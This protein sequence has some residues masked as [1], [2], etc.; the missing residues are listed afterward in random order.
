MEKEP[1]RRFRSADEFAH[2][3]AAS[4]VTT[5]V[6]VPLTAPERTERI[7]PAPDLAK[8]ALFGP[9]WPWMKRIGDRSRTLIDKPSRAGLAIL[10]LFLLVI[11]MLAFRTSG[12][13]ST[14]TPDVR[15][16]TIVEA[17]AVMQK[18][19]LKADLSYRPVTSGRA[20]IVAETVPAQG[21]KVPRGSSV[22]VIATAF[23]TTPTPA[24]AVVR[25]GAPFP[26]GGARRVAPHK[27]K[28]HKG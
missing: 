16:K 18:A 9:L 13:A 1:S 8:V 6:T 17:V 24:P 14:V 27:A 10:L 23:A 20:G 15:G 28:G 26:S 12:S 11:A 4:E 5:P 3:F 21:V 7:A 25:G 2:A 22:H 19:G